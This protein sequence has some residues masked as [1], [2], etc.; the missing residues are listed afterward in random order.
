MRDRVF[1]SICFGFVF[2]VLMRSLAQ[3]NIYFVVLL[4]ILS[5]A[6]FLFYI[7]VSKDKWGIILSI[8][9]FS[10][11]LGIL[12]FH[13]ADVPPPEFF[14]SQIGQKAPF[15]GIIVD[16]PDTREASTKLTVLAEGGEQKTKALLSLPPAEYLKYGDEITFFGKLEKPENFLTDQGKEFDYINY[17]RKDGIFYVMKNPKIEIISE[18]GGNLVKRALFNLKEKFLEK[19]NM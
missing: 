6:V 9:L 17:L 7:F 16:E 8:F 11:S 3:V 19:I 15:S 13:L 18:N 5:F 1:H 4:V 12:R 2:G 10:F 14:E